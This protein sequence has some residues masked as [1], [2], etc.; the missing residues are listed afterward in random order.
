[1]HEIVILQMGST[2]EPL[3]RQIGDFDKWVFNKI[4]QKMQ[5]FTTVV[6][7][8]QFPDYILSNNPRAILITGSH[9]MVTEATNVELKCFD[10][11]KKAIC[12]PKELKNTPAVFGICYGHQLLAHLL[13][14]KAAQR[15][16]GPEIGLVDIEFSANG[17][18]LF[19]KYDK[20]SMPFF[21][22][23]YQCAQK[24]PQNA[25]LLASSTSEMHHAFRVDGYGAPIYGVQFHPE[26]PMEACVYY[27]EQGISATVSEHEKR[28]RDIRE[29]YIDNTIIAD[30]LDMVL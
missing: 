10:A 8:E 30:F 17:D 24:L 14:G 4:P 23:H 5:K 1:M 20:K 27:D 29:R 22:V 25:K 9:G 6:N 7:S 2:Y 21:A 19:Q 26:F 28:N 15:V 3:I 11:L 16:D 12:R 18:P 13:G